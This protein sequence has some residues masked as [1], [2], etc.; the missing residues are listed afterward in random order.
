ML[1]LVIEI[2]YSVSNS[3]RGGYN[4]KS[5]QKSFGMFLLTSSQRCLIF[6]RFVLL[7]KKIRRAGGTSRPSSLAAHYLAQKGLAGECLYPR[8]ERIRLY[9]LLFNLKLPNFNI[10]W[11]PLYKVKQVRKNRIELR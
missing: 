8:N 1:D 4:S 11:G 2:S 7:Q 5:F 9:F 3:H 10:A 6:M